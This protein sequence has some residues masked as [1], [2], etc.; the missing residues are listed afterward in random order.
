MGTIT[1]L[2]DFSTLLDPASEAV[3]WLATIGVAAAEDLLLLMLLVAVAVFV[4]VAAV[5]S[6]A[7]M[8]KMTLSPQM[9]SHSSRSS[10]LQA[11]SSTWTSM[12]QASSAPKAESFENEIMQVMQRNPLQ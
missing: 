6:V 4:V 5:D 12:V 2:T 11:W 3:A 7:E 1:S 9:Q 8:T 10:R